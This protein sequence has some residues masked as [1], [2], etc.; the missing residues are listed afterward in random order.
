MTRWVLFWRR[1]SS[2]SASRVA[3]SLCRDVSHKATT[4]GSSDRPGMRIRSQ[5]PGTPAARHLATCSRR[6]VPNSAAPAARSVRAISGRPSAPLITP[7][8]QIP[9]ALQRE[10]TA[11]AL[12]CSRERSISNWGYCRTAT[13]P[14][15]SIG[16]LYHIRCGLSHLFAKFPRRTAKAVPPPMRGALPCPARKKETAEAVS[17]FAGV[18]T[19]LARALLA[20]AISA[21]M[22]ACFLATMARMTNSVPTIR[23]TAISR[24]TNTFWIRPAR[25]KLTKDTAATVSA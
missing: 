10:I 4:S 3:H 20:S 22:P 19:Y 13:P 21:K 1:H 8:T 18:C 6:L 9:A 12:L 16:I 7:Q 11:R 24:L 23:A 2:S 25:M 17:F 15:Y 14:I 5:G